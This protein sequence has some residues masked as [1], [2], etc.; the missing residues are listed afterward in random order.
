[1]ALPVLRERTKPPG[2]PHPVSEP[3]RK[4]CQRE[5]DHTL[6]RMPSKLALALSVWD[7]NKKV[8]GAGLY[9]SFVLHR[10]GL[11]EASRRSGAGRR[12]AGDASRK[13]IG[14]GQSLLCRPGNPRVR[15]FG[16][17]PRRRRREVGHLGC[18]EGVRTGDRGWNGCR[19]FLPAS[20][21][22]EPPWAKRC[23]IS[24]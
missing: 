20:Q 1:M 4:R 8:G 12:Q 11:Q 13:P 5:S 17:I 9:L 6:F 21:D 10:F 16:E 15:Q 24:H 3:S 7:G 19:P 23:E 18:R 14:K 2:A 22:Y